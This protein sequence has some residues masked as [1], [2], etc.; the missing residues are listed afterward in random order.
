[1]RTRSRSNAG[2]RINCALDAG[3]I[4]KKKFASRG[5]IDPVLIQRRFR[6]NF[7]SREGWIDFYVLKN[8]FYCSTGLNR[9][10]HC[11]RARKCVT[12]GTMSIHLHN[13]FSYSISIRSGV[14]SQNLQPENVLGFPFKRLQIQFIYWRSV[15]VT[16]R[17]SMFALHQSSG[18]QLRPVW[19]FIHSKNVRIDITVFII[20][21]CEDLIFQALIWMLFL[22]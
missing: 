15:H 13:E 9:S 11:C 8:G 14:I 7:G 21:N 22:R 1:M 12:C 3:A 18:F 2:N 16:R 10:I 17:R 6:D 5:K 19:L 4:S 20:N